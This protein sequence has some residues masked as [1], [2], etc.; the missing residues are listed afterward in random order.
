MELLIDG[1]VS[2]VL[3]SSSLIK[4]L[5]QVSELY[6]EIYSSLLSKLNEAILIAYVFYC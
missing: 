2:N 5:L 4:I 6:P 3:H 1:E